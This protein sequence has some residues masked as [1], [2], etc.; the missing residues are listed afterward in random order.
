[1][2]KHSMTNHYVKVSL[3][4]VIRSGIKHT[5]TPS[6]LLKLLDVFRVAGWSQGRV[7]CPESGWCGSGTAKEKPDG[8]LGWWSVESPSPSFRFCWREGKAR[9]RAGGR[10]VVR[11]WQR[12][13]FV[14]KVPLPCRKPPDQEGWS[15]GCQGGT[16][17]ESQRSGPPSPARPWCSE[18]TVWGGKSKRGQ[19]KGENGSLC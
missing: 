17:H 14:G 4:P 2:A 16:G 13:K 8:R 5:R 3:K 7:R 18:C 15:L 10:A 19:W 1:M 9:A 6:V 11:S 12:A